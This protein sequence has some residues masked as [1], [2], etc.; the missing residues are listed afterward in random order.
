MRF[1]HEGDNLL[2]NTAGRP[3]TIPCRNQ[4]LGTVPPSLELLDIGLQLLDIT[5]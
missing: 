3:Y 1:D 2:V 4:S 5:A